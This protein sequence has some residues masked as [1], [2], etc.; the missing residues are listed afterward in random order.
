MSAPPA[1]PSYA[2]KLPGG[3]IRPFYLVAALLLTWFVGVHGLNTGFSYA[4]FLRSGTLPDLS[5]AAKNAG[6]M[7]G[8]LEAAGVEALKA[9]LAHGRV[10]FPLAVAEV[11]LSGLLVVASGL[12]LGGRRGSRS[13]ALQAIV[14]NAL[15]AILEYLITPG[16]RAGYTEGWIHAVATL[17]VTPEERDILT[18]VGLLQWGFRLRLGFYLGAL[19]LGALALTRERA[20]SFFEAVARA[21]ERPEEP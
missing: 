19:A 4:S 21:A 15:L 7:A 5:A 18:N 16:V 6:A 2:P 9:M 20:K 1:K 17:S 12:A 3:R 11:I 13:L 10:T 14:A 8:V